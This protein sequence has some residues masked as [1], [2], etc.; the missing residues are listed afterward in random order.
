MEKCIYC[1]KS[2]TKKG[3]SRHRNKCKETYN[4]N[5]MISSEQKK[6]CYIIKL[7]GDCLHIISDFLQYRDEFTTY[8]RY[9]I[10]KNRANL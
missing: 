6:E 8:A 5:E 3:I 9:Y 2:Y 4:N 7:P 10:A 1:E